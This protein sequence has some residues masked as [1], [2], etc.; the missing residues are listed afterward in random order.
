MAKKKY[1]GKESRSARKMNSQT[2]ISE[3]DREYA[4][5]P[6]ERIAR[7]FPMMADFAGREYGDTLGSVD[8]DMNERIRQLDRAQAKKRF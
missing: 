4:T 7:E 2:M 6:Q 8:A 5:L 1:Y 3:N